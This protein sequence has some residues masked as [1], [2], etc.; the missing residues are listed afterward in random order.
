[1]FP[2]REPSSS[3][4]SARRTD[5][6]LDEPVQIREVF[7]ALENSLNRITETIHLQIIRK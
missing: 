7:E 6:F 2:I 4:V 1:M 5:F 3:Q